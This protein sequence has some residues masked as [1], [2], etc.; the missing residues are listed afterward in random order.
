MRICI[1][2]GHGGKDPG[3]I[4]RLNSKEKDIV[5]SISLKL[6]EMLINSKFDVI[7][8]REKDELPNNNKSSQYNLK[9]RCD[10]AKEHK[11]DIFVSIHCNS[12]KD[13]NAKGIETYYYKENSILLARCIQNNLTKNIHT[14]NRGIKKA[15]FYVLK[16]SYIPS[17]LT[18]IGFIS[19]I[20]EEKMMINSKYQQIYA[21]AIFDGIKDFVNSIKKGE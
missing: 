4:G 9:I 20:E 8:T 21:K 10:I 7:L 17:V 11:C 5:L 19:N 15:T 14:L 13:T 6:R 12:S 16:N 18:E 3:A 2:P 1:D